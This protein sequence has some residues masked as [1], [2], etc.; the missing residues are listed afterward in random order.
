M[1]HFELFGLICQFELDVNSL[2][3]KYL[4]LQRRF[5]PDKFVIA[6]RKERQLAVQKITQINDAYQTLRDPMH[7][8]EYMISLK[9]LELCDE[10][11]MMT[12]HEFLLQQME[13]RKELEEIAESDEPDLLLFDFEKKT[14]SIHKELLSELADAFDDACYVA[15]ATLVSKLKFLVKLKQEIERIEDR[16]LD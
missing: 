8:A 10:Q 16:L 2:F 11:Q 15:A 9:G 7:R 13:L 3:Y 14:N 4:D 6:S 1:N 5:H 12:D